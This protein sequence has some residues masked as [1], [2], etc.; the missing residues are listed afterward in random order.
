MKEATGSERRRQ[1]YGG[2]SR[3]T[4]RDSRHRGLGSSVSSRAHKA[5]ACYL[6]QLSRE[7]Y[8]TRNIA[9][10]FPERDRD[11]DCDSDSDSL[12]LPS[13]V[14]LPEIASNAVPSTNRE[15]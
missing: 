15:D 2:R 7:P 12:G 3:R 11:R 14:I 9:R 5:T 4:N 1:R 6:G 10:T 8:L 13:L